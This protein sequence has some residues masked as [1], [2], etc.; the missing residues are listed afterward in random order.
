[1]NIERSS[2]RKI[3]EAKRRNTPFYDLFEAEEDIVTE[4]TTLIN[5]LF[6]P[7]TWIL[8]E[9]LYQRVQKEDK[10]WISIDFLHRNQKFQSILKKFEIPAH[11]R[12]RKNII[13]KAIKQSLIKRKK[14]LIKRKEHIRITE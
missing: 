8:E 4:L 5:S 2:H 12:R 6:A 7:L 13:N 10:G 9:T 1:M 3:Y 11:C 14:N